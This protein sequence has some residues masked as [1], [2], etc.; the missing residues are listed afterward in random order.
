MRSAGCMWTQRAY[1]PK[2]T[3]EQQIKSRG[4]PA[5]IA[6]VDL[7]VTEAPVWLQL[8]VLMACGMRLHCFLVNGLTQLLAPQLGSP[9]CSSIASMWKEDTWTYAV[10][11]HCPS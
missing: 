3:R 1:Q 10:A 11:M 5:I 2:L 6:V 8:E 4:F 9:V 7:L